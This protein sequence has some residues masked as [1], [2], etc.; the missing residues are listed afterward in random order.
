CPWITDGRAGASARDSLL[1]RE[2]V[3]RIAGADDDVLAAVEQVGL[4]TVG[5]VR[6][7]AGVP[8]RLSGCRVVG[9][10]VAAA[11]VA[12]EQAA[13]GAEQPHGAAQAAGRAHRERTGPLHLAG[14]VVD[15]LQR[16]ADVA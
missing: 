5:R 13:R 6:P 7:E 3:E 9:D 11:V 14:L 2:R 8:E 15:R 4:R 12:E 10:E 1:E 16:V